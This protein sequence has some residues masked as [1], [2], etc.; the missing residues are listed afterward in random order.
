MIEV[1]RFDG[2]PIVKPNPDNGWEARATFNGCVAKEDK[3]FHIVYRAI[4]SSVQHHGREMEVSSIGYAESDDGVQFRNTRQLIKPEFDWEKFGCEDPRITKIDGKY[5]I[6]YTALS[7][8][9]PSPTGIKIGVAV[10]KDFEKLEKHSVTFFN[11]KAMALFPEKING[12]MAAVLTVNTDYPPSKIC[13][14]LFD[15]EEEIWSEDYWTKWFSS[16]DKHVIPLSRSGKDQVEIGAPPVKTKDGWLL[17]YCYIRNY[18]SPPAIFGIEA[19]LLDLKD[20]SKIIRRLERPLFVPEMNYERYG[21]VPNVIFPSGALVQDENLLIYYGAADTT[22]C[23]AACNIEQLLNEILMVK[24]KRFDGNPIIKPIDE[25]PLES[26][27]TFNPTA[28]YENGKVHI[29]YRSMGDN[30]TSVMGYATS[31]DGFNI[32]ERLPDPIYFPR[33]EFESKISR[34]NSGCEDPR[35]TKIDGKFYMCYTAYD[36]RNPPRV[37]LTS[38]KADDFL[39]KR[40]IWTKPVLISP[41]GIDDKDACIFPEKVNG[42]YLVMHRFTPSIWIDFVS[43]LNDFG[44]NKKWLGGIEWFKP[45]P[46]KWDSK[47]VGIGGLPIKTKNGWLLIYH[48]IGDD[49]KYRLGAMLLDLKNPTKIIAILDYPILEPEEWYERGGLTSHVVFTC[50]AVVINDELFVY[51]GGADKYVGVATVN[52]NELLEELKKFRIP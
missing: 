38:I 14:A 26:K 42:K 13:L 37:A 11:S 17:I 39:N 2:N 52:L 12:K 19:V 18:L 22:C 10:T 46:G 35:I 44:E 43:N 47:K 30:D 5:F 48:A 16:L 40:W 51:Y 33:E 21:N 31:K 4:S 15:K 28:I 32:D 7:E 36:A 34:G 23:I 25:S 27:A 1:K 3:K 6:F 49:N 41:P 45:R 8:W 20:P 50:G 29:I 9:P 24:L